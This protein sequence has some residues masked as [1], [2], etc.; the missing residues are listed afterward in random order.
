MPV[1]LKHA[2]EGIDAPTCLYPARPRVG[3]GTIASGRGT[4]ARA[5]EER[6]PEHA[7]DDQGT[8]R[9]A[10]GDGHSADPTC[11]SPF[12]LHGCHSQKRYK[13]KTIIKE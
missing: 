3:R 4:A 7:P 11:A 1:H 2:T 12:H 9:H 13:G 8:C 10:A 6:S 5:G